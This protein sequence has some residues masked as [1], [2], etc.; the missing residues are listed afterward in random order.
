[1]SCK[2]YTKKIQELKGLRTEKFKCLFLLLCNVLLYRH[3]RFEVAGRG[4]A[5]VR[6]GDGHSLGARG[7]GPRQGHD[8][9]TF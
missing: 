8:D 1:M 3:V 6:E 9:L 7:S 2:K 4:V 5:Q